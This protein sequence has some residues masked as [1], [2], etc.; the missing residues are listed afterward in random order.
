MRNK[1]AVAAWKLWARAN[2]LPRNYAESLD[3]YVRAKFDELWAF[4][5]VREDF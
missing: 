5:Q 4:A 2:K 3:P 1:I